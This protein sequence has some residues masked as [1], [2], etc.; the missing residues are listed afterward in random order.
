MYVSY[1]QIDI[2]LSE[3]GEQCRMFLFLCAQR[4]CVFCLWTICI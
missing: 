1:V 4:N 3:S 2:Q